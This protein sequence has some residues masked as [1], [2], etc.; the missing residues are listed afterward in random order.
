MTPPKAR[1]PKARFTEENS[2]EIVVSQNAGAKDARL[3]QV[4]DSITRHLHAV[5]KETEPSQEEWMQAIQFLTATGRKCDD[6][7]QEYILL[8]DVLGVSMLVDAVNSRRPAGASENTVLGPFHIGGMPEYEMGAN[9]CLDAK[10][11]DMVVAGR[12]LDT[13]G[14][15]LSGVKIDVWQ[16]NDEGFYDVQQKDIQPEFN[17]RGV[18]R[19]GQDGAY[20][21]KGVRP[22]HYSIPADGPVGELLEALGRHPW[23][24]AHLHFIV[25]K[26][27][28]DDV[29]THI[30]DPDDPYIDSDAVFGVK[31]SLI[32][33]F[34]RVDDPAKVSEMGFAGPHFWRVDFNFVL[35]G[36]S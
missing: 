1:F 12:I 35:A 24:P 13:E 7:R 32:A 20:W 2:A 30:F 34:V 5:V 11:E 25:S 29:T 9:I 14:N 22:K 26:D 18:F 27:G 15:S 3:K 28:Y 19:T 21:F 4:M 8:S 31:E 23:R 6:W 33:D 16:A 10:G 17:L 36:K